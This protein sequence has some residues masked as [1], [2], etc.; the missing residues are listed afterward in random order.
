VRHSFSSLA[1]FAYHLVRQSSLTVGE[2]RRRYKTIRTV[3]FH[4]ESST[5][6]WEKVYM[7]RNFL[8]RGTAS[9]LEMFSHC[10]RAQGARQPGRF[11]ATAS[12]QA[13]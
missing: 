9:C 2:A 10:L 4:L 13:R 8:T 1:S 7:R 11:A 12:L 5:L 6:R 3:S